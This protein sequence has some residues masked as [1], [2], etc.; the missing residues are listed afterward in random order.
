M[1]A[2]RNNQLSITSP[3]SALPPTALLTPRTPRTAIENPLETRSLPASPGLPSSVQRRGKRTRAEKERD[4]IRNLIVIACGLVVCGWYV[5]R[6]LY[7]PESNHAGNAYAPAS[8][9]E[10]EYEMVGD[11]LP[12]EEPSVVV[13]T[14]SRGKPKWTIS[15]PAALQWPLQ[16]EQ[17]VELCEQSMEIS[18]TIAEGANLLTKRERQR[19][20]HYVDP[21]FVDVEAAGEQG[22][23]PKTQGT[24]KLISALGWDEG[25][26]DG[27]EKMGRCD[28]SLTYVM[29]SEEAGMGKTL[30]GLWLA[31]GLAK[32]E[33]RAFFVDD[34][35]WSYGNYTT[36]F[37][38]PPKPS[39]LPPLTT[40][41]VPCPHH[42]SH[43]LVSAATTSWTFGAS[44]R[45][46]YE[47]AK[48]PTETERQHRIFA[49][50]RTGYE[51]L[52]HLNPSDA[53]YVA[54]RSA[55]LF[56]PVREAGGLAIGLHVRRGDRHPFEFQ[57]GRDYIPMDR[58]LSTAR[59]ILSSHF[60]I[61]NDTAASSPT[62]P[63]PS[64]SHAAAAMDPTASL[65]STIP[66][67]LLVLATDDPDIYTSPEALAATAIRAQ[68][69]I[70][71]ASKAA[72]E[73]TGARNRNKY[74][75]EISGWEGGFF[76]DV[77]WS[78]GR[79]AQR[80]KGDE[81]SEGAMR[82]RE[83]VGR[84][85]L[86]DLGVV[87]SADRTVC[88][89]SAVGCRVLGVMRGWED[90]LGV[91]GLGWVNVDGGESGWVAV[92]W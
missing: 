19:G 41:V 6:R 26:V 44:F 21:H 78:L 39:C 36:Y 3:S 25:V 71:L 31:Y 43:L 53:A 88:A 62:T 84:A 79:D 56:E 77:F 65:L 32:E 29:E 14:D 37:T 35:R 18:H 58:Y 80:R 60:H 63:V 20:Y 89:V 27:G 24:A 68:D 51:A 23:L 28:R 7:R 91:D 34:T 38:P 54:D 15:I 87:A 4:L 42:A 75:D 10:W 40:Q 86:L 47:D 48:K 82:M 12:P 64:S 85:Y 45:E 69:R 73:A 61:D 9:G 59:T 1:H 17:Y 55:E 49:L 13:V 2:R 90:V 50:L 33:G 81:V 92:D 70:V 83:L 52:F 8:S 22:L 57:Y 11:Y 67:S 46:E 5:V 66:H 30:M 74:I 16:P 72:L 76:R